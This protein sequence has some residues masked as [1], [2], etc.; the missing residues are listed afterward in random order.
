[1][2]PASHIRAKFPPRLP[3]E[4]SLARLPLASRG[5]SSSSQP[6]SCHQ[7]AG[8]AHCILGAVSL[9][10][11]RKRRLPKPFSAATRNAKAASP[12][13]V[14]VDPL[15][16][17]LRL[18]GWTLKSPILLAPMEC[19]NDC[20]YRRMCFEQGAGLTFTEMVR[21]QA[22]TR[23]NR[24]TLVRLDTYDPMTPTIVQLLGSAPQ[25]IQSALNTLDELAASDYP[26][27]AQGIHGVDLNFGCPS[28][29]VI[30][31]GQG[32]ALLRRVSLLRE[33]FDVLAQ[34]RSRTS[35]PIGAIGAKIRLGVSSDDERR[36]IYLRAVKMAK[37]VGFDYVVVHGRHAREDSK[38]SKARWEPIRRA[39]DVA[40]DSLKILGNGDVLTR[41]DARAMMQQTG[42]DGVL[43]ARGAVRTAG[44][45]FD[46][47]WQGDDHSVVAAVDK[48]ERR[49]AELSEQFGGSRPQVAE[50]HREAFRRV[51]ARG[52]RN[53]MR[54]K[55][56]GLKAWLLDAH[57]AL[58]EHTKAEPDMA[59]ISEYF[60]PDV[61]IRF[62]C[63]SP[64]A[65]AAHC[66]FAGVVAFLPQ[67]A[68]ALSDQKQEVH[69]PMEEAE[70]DPR[71]IFVALSN[72]CTLTILY[73]EDNR[74]ARV[75]MLCARDQVSVG[76]WS[77]AP[78]MG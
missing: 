1:M 57:A 8:S 39:K 69:V 65:D 44:I 76:E 77:D 78:A 17:P 56:Q 50:Y 6:R 10:L 58:G 67:L 20:A 27:W 40:G 70:H 34:W 28:F 60:S 64:L 31:D 12:G 38:T 26:H 32:P 35:L 63:L 61:Q 74:V 47:T 3:V 23:H 72:T 36:G 66:G 68:R 24:S 4:L 7:V 30:R 48:L 14:D 45:I 9:S 73:A 21:P 22:V 18:G 49:Y 62:S 52:A 55:W 2:E 71:Q 16:V 19:V 37:D 54:D 59:R 43:V 15:S 41:D 33:I 53:A 51:R 29:N 11:K 46:P 42:C 5:A 75:N 25:D 13:N